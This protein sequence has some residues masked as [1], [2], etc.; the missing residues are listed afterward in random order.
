M[1]R[2]V[3]LSIPCAIIFLGFAL[4]FVVEGTP[5][6]IVALVVILAGTVLL[7]FIEIKSKKSLEKDTLL[8][9][10]LNTDA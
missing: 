7:W 8:N 10:I 4:P 5:G 9:K 2:I 1:I 3:L 6:L